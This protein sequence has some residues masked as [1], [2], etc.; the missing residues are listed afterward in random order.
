MAYKT[1]FE[2]LAGE[3]H[4]ISFGFPDKPFEGDSQFGHWW[5]Y[6]VK[7]N[8]VDHSWFVNEFQHNMIAAAKPP[9]NVAVKLEVGQKRS[10]AGKPYNVFQLTTPSG[11]FSSD[12]DNTPQAQPPVQQPVKPTVQV[13]T[14]ATMQADPTE[15]L[16]REER[17]MDWCMKTIYKTTHY[18]SDISK[19]FYESLDKTALIQS[20][21]VHV[22]SKGIYP[23]DET[24]QELEE[25][26]DGTP[27]ERFEA[28]NEPPPPTD[29]DALP[30]DDE[31]KF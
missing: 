8:G 20:L 29:N 28:T 26:L 17:L 30:F 27:E 1:K 7:V 25:K 24:E 12:G 9:K 13:N 22:R 31:P 2:P 16:K 5:N 6:A 4:Q 21:H 11:T 19:E 23:P 14:Q 15:L 18:V 10:Q 3:S